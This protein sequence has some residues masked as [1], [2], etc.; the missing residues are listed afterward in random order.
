MYFTKEDG[1][2]YLLEVMMRQVPGFR[3]RRSGIRIVDPDLSITGIFGEGGKEE[4]KLRMERYDVPWRMRRDAE[5]RSPRDELFRDEDHRTR[6][7]EML[8]GS[9]TSRMLSS[10]RYLAAVFLLSADGWLW[11]RVKTSVTDLGIFFDNV[12]IRGASTEQYVLFHSA[13]EIFTGEQFVSMEEMADSEIV[14]DEL[15]SL[16]V[17]AY[18]LRVAGLGL[19][20]EVKNNG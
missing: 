5:G 11:E 9:C 14:S 13:K 20:G 19:A 17:S 6:F 3:Q 10:G 15:L 8:D 4:M 7:R 2:A 18:L 16:I 1:E 12:S